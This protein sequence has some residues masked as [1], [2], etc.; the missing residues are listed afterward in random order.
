MLIMSK[1]MTRMP[2]LEIGNLA[3]R[4]SVA[5]GATKISTTR[6]EGKTEDAG[7]E[8]YHKQ[9][10]LLENGSERKLGCDDGS[11]I[12]EVLGVYWCYVIPF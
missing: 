10:W 2:I 8:R 5:V 1:K 3:N 6:W 9:A 12:Y 4:D 11:G 7:Q